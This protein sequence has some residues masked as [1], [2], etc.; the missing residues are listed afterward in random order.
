[1]YPLCG[2]LSKNQPF[3][4]SGFC[5]RAEAVYYR[6]MIHSLRGTVTEVSDAFFVIECAGVGYRVFTNRKTLGRVAVGAPA[7]ALCYHHVREDQNELFGFLEA[8]SLKLFE[9]LN[10]VGGVGPKTALGVLDVD[11][12]T[13]LFA[14]IIERRVDLLTHA[15]GIGKKTAERI[16]LELQSKI[17]MAGSGEATRGADR[18]RDVEDVLT[19]L[20]YGRSDIRSAIDALGFGAET[21]V[22]ERLRAVLKKLSSG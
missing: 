12:T 1:M 21:P 7:F 2:V 6:G 4:Q 16:I 14:A 18:N 15:S 20:G 11:S 9:M 17:S 22:E 19:D 10:T 13:N 8:E 5:Y 3:Y